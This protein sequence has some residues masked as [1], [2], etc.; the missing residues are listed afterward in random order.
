M[1][2]GHFLLERDKLF[3]L[4]V[5]AF[6]ATSNQGFV[7]NF[8]RRRSFTHVCPQNDQKVAYIRIGEVTLPGVDQVN[9]PESVSTNDRLMHARNSHQN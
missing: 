2:D 4:S 9:R 5:Y 6:S 1:G 3:A 8:V 7:L